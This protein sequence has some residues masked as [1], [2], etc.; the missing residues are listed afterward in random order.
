[1]TH[2]QI[3]IKWY[4]IKTNVQVLHQVDLFLSLNV[5]HLCFESAHHIALY[6]YIYGTAR[7]PDWTRNS[8]SHQL[9]LL[10]IHPYWLVIKETRFNSMNATCTHAA[11]ILPI[12]WVSG[13]LMVCWWL[14]NGLWIPRIWNHA[15][16]LILNIWKKIVL[17]KIKHDMQKYRVEVGEVS[18]NTTPHE[19]AHALGDASRIT[20]GSWGGE[21]EGLWAALCE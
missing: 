9:G 1:M 7:C 12:D 2:V 8:I 15:E 16:I 10:K 14:F 21:S 6:H 13:H 11:Q 20:S 19:G 5:I 3:L 17:L 4:P 18:G